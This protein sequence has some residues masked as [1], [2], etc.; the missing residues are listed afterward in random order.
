MTW[1]TLYV[2]GGAHI[3]P[4]GDLKGHEESQ[5]CW[6]CPRA[7]DGEGGWLMVH[8]AMDR[9]EQYETLQ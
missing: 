8:N 5:Y 3:I 1:Q 2:W 9:R 6:C 4:V 7:I